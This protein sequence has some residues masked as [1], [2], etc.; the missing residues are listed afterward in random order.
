MNEQTIK[1]KCASHFANDSTDDINWKCVLWNGYGCNLIVFITTFQY[2]FYLDDMHLPE[3]KWV[4][5]FHDLF[6]TFLKC[7]ILQ[8]TIWRRKK[9]RLNLNQKK[10]ENNPK[11][12]CQ[13]FWFKFIRKCKGYQRIVAKYITNGTFTFVVLLFFFFFIWWPYFI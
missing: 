12:V 11:I 2:T 10:S 13:F 4:I 7:V 1:W 5:S 6:F 3:G 8:I 9:K